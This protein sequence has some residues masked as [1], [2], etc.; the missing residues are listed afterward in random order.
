MN[1]FALIPGPAAP[2]PLR[3][4]APAAIPLLEAGQL[5]E[6]HSDGDDRA[7]ACAFALAWGCTGFGG[8]NKGAIFMVRSARRSR[9]PLGL[10]GEGLLLLG[11]DPARLVLVDTP[12]E[13]ELLRAALD[14]VRCIQAGTVVMETE[15]PLP[16]YDL[17][18]SRR[19]VLAAERSGSRVIVLR[20]D[21]PPRA[22]AA[23]ARWAIRSAPS[24]PLEARA[25]GWPALEVQLQR[26]RGGP[27]GQSWRLEWDAGHGGFRQVA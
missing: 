27:A 6:I 12:D 8:E 9:L 13:M 24:V 22:S 17:T 5:H 1:T 4:R 26:Q 10:Y 14:A 19:L 23:Q 15:G 25:P 18:T 21:A 20:R 11:I 2:T 7:G 3:Q 16:R